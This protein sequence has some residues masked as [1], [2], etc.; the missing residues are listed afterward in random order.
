MSLQV[1]PSI[2]NDDTTSH[3]QTIFTNL[4]C[5]LSVRRLCAVVDGVDI[6]G[7]GGGGEAV[8]KTFFFLKALKKRPEK[9]PPVLKK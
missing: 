1:K 8:K 7:G 5:H 2:Q 3:R 4:A 9:K 6:S